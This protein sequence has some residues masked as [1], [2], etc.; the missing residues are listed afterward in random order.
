MA[1]KQYEMAQAYVAI[2][3]SLKGMSE[4]LSRQLNQAMPSASSALGKGLQGAMASATRGIGNV[5]GPGGVL[6]KAGGVLTRAMSS[7]IRGLGRELT[8]TLSTA[9]SVAGTAIGVGVTALGGQVLG[10]GL[11]RAL[12]INEAESRLKALGFTASEMQSVMDASAAAIDGTAYAMNE[13]V[14]AATQFIAAGITNGEELESVLS[15]TGKLADIS[16][17]SFADMGSLMSKNASAGIVQWE[18]MIQL[19]DAGV[20]IQSY[21]AEQLG[22][23]TAEIK[24]MASEGKITFDMFNSAVGAIE[25]DSATYAAENVSL[26]FRNVRS[27]LS[28]IGAGLW[29][30]IIDG[31]GPMLVSVRNG[32]SDLQSTPFFTE[33]MAKIAEKLSGAME[34]ISNAVSG[35]MS[36][37]G[38]SD[39]PITSAIGAWNSFREAISGLEGPIVGIGVAM[40]S[41]LLSQ[42]PVVGSLFTRVSMG[43]GLL[44]GALVQAYTQSES[45]QG[46]IGGLVDTL[47]GTVSEFKGVGDGWAQALG[48]GLAKVITSINSVLQN[49]SFGEGLDV[50]TMFESV[51]TGISDFIDRIAEESDRIGGAI[52]LVVDAFSSAFSGVGDVSNFGDWL[53]GVV[54]NVAVAAATLTATAIPI[55]I[56]VAKGLATVIASDFVQGILG[57]LVDVGTWLASNQTALTVLGSIL[58][59]AF[60]AGKVSGPLTA[61]VGFFKGFSG[62]SLEAA[63]KAMG[64]GLKGVIKAIGSAGQAMISALPQI[65]MGIGALGLIIGAIAG[66]SAI[67]E[68]TGA[69][70][71]LRNL[72]AV[73]S[74]LILG[75]VQLIADALG[76][77]IQ[78]LAQ[79]AQAL[80][81]ILNTLWQFI[82][83]VLQ[84]ILTN[85][86]TILTTVADVLVQLVNVLVDSIAT[87]I[88]AIG[89]GLALIFASVGDLL[90][91]LATNGMDAGAGAAAAAAGIYALAG[92]LVALS[93]GGLLSS[94]TSG[95]GGLWTAFTSAVSGKDTS[96]AG[97]LMEI[98]NAIA[99]AGDVIQTLPDKIGEVGP[100]MY[101]VGTSIMR[102]FQ[103][104]ALTQIALSQVLIVAALN[105]MLNGLQAHL[106]SNPLK[107]RVD[108]SA[109]NAASSA[110]GVTS[111]TNNNYNM[112]TNNSTVF[113]RLLR[114]AR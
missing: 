9:G 52:S 87:L 41:G 95:L 111:T 89:E 55:I 32:L 58:A 94:V 88:G 31:L 92:S 10:G 71:A 35:F 39:G 61:M 74:E 102:S 66:V 18:D 65:L 27:Q 5:F 29:E 78:M 44:G 101:T 96:Q 12:G 28:K 53:G 99:K 79:N 70:D 4:E 73:L 37:L 83:P 20:P 98:A 109:V 3:P 110:G 62:K 51:F 90:I 86:L 56:G 6:G 14:G 49:V 36:T 104:G 33:G 16:G 80:G 17:R 60:I 15:N 85:V 7:S 43:A 40:S 63:G 72:G 1:G 97:Q 75:I 113:D 24:K 91:N 50:A 8:N 26:A 45:L 47:T 48:D 11:T 64:G 112:T 59:G 23:S 22:K 108:K 107:V 81:T 68:A 77:L 93:G 84:F 21:L 25:F 103:T 100:Q 46:A 2:L 69:Y 106:D 105:S 30:P 114:S 19:I 76:I 67:L 82:E 42:L 54:A 34:T 38:Q 57:W 13:S